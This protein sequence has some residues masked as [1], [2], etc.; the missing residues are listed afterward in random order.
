MTI[1]KTK[2]PYYN[3]TS[4]ILAN[5]ATLI[6]SLAHIC[7]IINIANTVVTIAMKI[8]HFIG[9][10]AADVNESS[11]METTESKCMYI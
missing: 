6:L 4:W 10:S 3:N 2:S 9:T 5:L 11:H 8:S 7:N 1:T